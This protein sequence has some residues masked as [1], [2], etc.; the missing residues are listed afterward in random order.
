ML[1]LLTDVKRARRTLDVIVSRFGSGANP[2]SARLGFYSIDEPSSPLYAISIFFS[3]LLFWAMDLS[4][5]IFLSCDIWIYGGDSHMHICRTSQ[6]GL[7]FDLLAVAGTRLKRL[8]YSPAA[9]K[10]V[11]LP[12]RA[13]NLSAKIWCSCSHFSQDLHNSHQYSSAARKLLLNNSSFGDSGYDSG[14]RRVTCSQSA[15]LRF[16][17]H[18]VP[19]KSHATEL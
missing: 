13:C 5:G 4:G 8:F 14:Q 6:V 18:L 17:F 2:G 3:T 19:R 7:F 11:V 10:V 1:D 16:S 9:L 15:S 12:Q